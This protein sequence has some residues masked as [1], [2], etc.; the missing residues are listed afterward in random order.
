MKNNIEHRYLK[1]YMGVQFKNPMSTGVELVNP[2]IKWETYAVDN[3]KWYLFYLG[4]TG[5][6]SSILLTCVLCVLGASWFSEYTGYR[7][8]WLGL[9]TGEVIFIISL[10]IYT[11]NDYFPNRR[12]KLNKRR[13]VRIS[14]TIS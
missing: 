13:A 5:I 12:R 4:W 1:T 2:I 11:L 8:G 14:D 6:V 9:L 3:P 7:S 10:F